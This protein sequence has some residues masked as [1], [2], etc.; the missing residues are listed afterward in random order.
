MNIFIKANTAEMNTVQLP[1][2]L[3]PLSFGTDR[4]VWFILQ[5]WK[6]E[7][8]STITVMKSPML[9]FGEV[10]SNDSWYGV[11]TKGMSTLAFQ[12][13]LNLD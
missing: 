10:T 7:I 8:N 13:Q 6:L 12:T 3:C 2:R 4:C 1:L 9:L 5:R 11:C